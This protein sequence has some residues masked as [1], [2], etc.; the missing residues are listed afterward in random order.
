MNSANRGSLLAGA[1]KVDITPQD[2]TGLTNLWGRPFEGVHDR[3]Y[4]RA[5]VLDNGIN[6]AAIVAADLV[7]F[8]DTI[9]LRK[10]IEQEIG[11]P[12]EHIIITASHD[13]NAPRVGTTTP[14]AT[15]Q[16]GG[17]ATGEYTKFV[18]ECI[19]DVVRRAKEALQPA[20]VGIGRGTAD[21]NT[22]RDV[23]TAKG[24]RLG[25]NPDG[26]SEKTV[27][28]VKFETESGEPIALLM[29]YAVHAV[30]LGASNT[31]VT[32]DLAGAAERYVEQH[33]DGR[34]VALWTLGP[35]GD[36]NPK[37]MSYNEEPPLFPDRAPGYPIMDALG[38][39]LG[40]EV[41][42]VASQIERRASQVRIEADERVMSCPA[43]IP[44]RG[45]NS[46]T[47]AIQKVD[48]LNIRLGL[49][50]IDHIALTCV[51]GEVVTKIYWH[52]RQESPFSNTIMIT[53][54]NDRV[55]YIVDDA[56]YH[57]PTFESMASPFQPGHAESAIVNGLVE[58]M[59][60]Y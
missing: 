38:V 55:G 11:V 37:Y 6:S 43:R 47:M 54:A 5:L 51:S 40:E 33:Y 60:Q 46:T 35:A 36:Q 34:V 8:G 58:M 49:I 24:W 27:W 13:H 10:R 28:V 52:L 1:A 29:N 3:I 7:E 14:G 57:T 59:S 12:V 26:P 39:V 32:G 20:Q 31:L 21:V 53:L 2:L 23:F 42:R 56:G 48:A 9:E 45:G 30:V 15:A 16:K 22:N 50:L 19:V 4:V 44:P 17:P 25:T 18:Y 41:V